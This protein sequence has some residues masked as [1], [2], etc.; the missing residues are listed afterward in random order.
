MEPLSAYRIIALSDTHC[1]DPRFDA[2]LFNL[3][4]SEINQLKPDMIVVAGD[5]TVGGYREQFIEVKTYIDK[6]NCD[7]KVVIAGNHDSRNVGWVHFED[8]I[9]PRYAT[10]SF[11]FGVCCG[12]RLQETIRVVAC[13]SSKPDLNDGEVG[14]ER[15]GWIDRNFPDTQEFKLFILH[16]HL[17]SVPGTGRERNIVWDAGDVLSTLRQTSVDLVLCGH[18]HVPYIWQV[19]DLVIVNCGTVSTFRTRGY[20]TPS[21]NMIDVRADRIEVSIITPGV[22]KFRT[23]SFIRP[24]AFPDLKQKLAETT[25]EVTGRPRLET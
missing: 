1:G 11:P 25:V 10:F 14:R 24:K 12:E 3:A 22:D 15:Y 16:H 6:I 18:K 8:I 21:Y 5:L 19:G 9:G 20:T 2:D 17:V 4:V 13:D 23:E 7:R